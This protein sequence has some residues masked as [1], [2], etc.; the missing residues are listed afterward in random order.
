[1]GIRN[2]NEILFCLE[3]FLISQNSI[4]NTDRCNFH[5][6]AYFH[7]M[8]LC[9][10]TFRFLI[11]FTW[12]TSSHLVSADHITLNTLFHLKGF[13][14][15]ENQYLPKGQFTDLYSLFDRIC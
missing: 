6:K 11:L 4:L 8:D 13:Q 9:V 1:M 7:S 3:V 15:H 12:K 14:C 5:V 10:S 2:G